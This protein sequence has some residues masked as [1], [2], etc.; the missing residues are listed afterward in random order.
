M[1][2]TFSDG[3]IVFSFSNINLTKKTFFRDHDKNDIFYDGSLFV[4]LAY[5]ADSKYLNSESECY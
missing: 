4:C 5:S 3:H 2:F 1:T